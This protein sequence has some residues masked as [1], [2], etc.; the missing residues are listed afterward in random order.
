MAASAH[1]PSMQPIGQRR[2]TELLP[3]REP[4]CPP[5]VPVWGRRSAKSFEHRRQ[6]NKDRFFE[7]ADSFAVS[8]HVRAVAL[9][10]AQGRIVH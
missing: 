10:K 4:L 2:R 9:A 8:V 5:R 1:G 6:W 7:L 3:L